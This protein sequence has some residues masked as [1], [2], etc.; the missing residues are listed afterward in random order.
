VASDSQKAK[1]ERATS[2]ARFVLCAACSRGN[3]IIATAAWRA[4][5]CSLMPVKMSTSFFF[6]GAVAWLS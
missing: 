3:A 5:Y 2:V 6:K 4:P 1:D